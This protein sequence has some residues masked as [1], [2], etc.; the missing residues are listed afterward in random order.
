[1]KLTAPLHLV[2]S[3]KML[4]IIT[5]AYDFVAQRQLYQLYERNIIDNLHVLKRKSEN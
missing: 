5:P 2:L 1:M 3:L 4:G